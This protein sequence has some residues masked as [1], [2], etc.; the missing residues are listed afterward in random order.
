MDRGSCPMA[1]LGPFSVPLGHPLVLC[2]RF[3]LAGLRA[4]RLSLRS[5]QQ[6][7]SSFILAIG[8]LSRTSNLLGPWLAGRMSRFLL[9]GESWS[10]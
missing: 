9:P 4:N 5:Q 7:L 10:V 2:L 6:P 8:A 3:C 1:D